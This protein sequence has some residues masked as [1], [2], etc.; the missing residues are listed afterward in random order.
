MHRFL[1]AVGFSQY[2]TRVKCRELYDYVIKNSDNKEYVAGDEDTVH[3][4][5]HKSFGEN[6]GLTVDMEYDKDGNGNI[7]YCFPYLYGHGVSSEEDVS[8]ERHTDKESYAGVCDDIKVGVVL[9]FY[10]Q[11]SIPYLRCLK[12]NLLPFRGTTLTL[13]ALSCQ[14]TIMMPIAKNDVDKARVKKLSSNRN[15]LI[16]SARS[17]NEEAIESLTLEDMDTY[18]TIS[19]KI[20]QEDVFT[21]VDTY[22]M[23]YGLEC[24]L[25]SVLGEIT[26]LQVV[27]NTYTDEEIYQMTITCNEL[28]FDLGINKLDLLGEP[29][30]G[31]RFKGT[32]WMQGH[33][34]FPESV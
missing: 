16:A 21:L 27:R 8:V 29:Q 23:P 31:R 9:I 15:R 11:N 17:G 1:R 12:D 25:Y 5:Y 14:G 10:L 13:S 20:H 24:D 7:N 26:S 32:I 19:K 28:S 30:I 33:V 2:T 4:E 6:M 18:T 3:T 22:F 34:N